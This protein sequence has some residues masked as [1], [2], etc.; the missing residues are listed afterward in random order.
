[1]FTACAADL[2]LPRSASASMK[3]RWRSGEQALGRPA[4]EAMRWRGTGV[5]LGSV[6]CAALR[7]SREGRGLVDHAAAPGWSREYA[8]GAGVQDGAARR[9]RRMRLSSGGIGFGEGVDMN[10]RAIGRVSGSVA[11]GLLFACVAPA[12]AEDE[13]GA[14][15]AMGVIRP[16]AAG[17]QEQRFAL[18][19]Q[20][21]RG[22]VIDL[23]RPALHPA[24]GDEESSAPEMTLR[25]LDAAGKCVQ[26]A[27]QQDDCSTPRGASARLREKAEDGA[28]RLAYRPEQGGSYTLIVHVAP[29]SGTPGGDRAELV[30]RER[31]IPPLPV[32]QAITLCQDALSRAAPTRP[33]PNEEAG[34]EAPATGDC[35]KPYAMDSNGESY[36]TFTAP[37]RE[38]WVR[39]EMRSKDIDSKVELL[40]PIRPAQ[41]FGDAPV[42]G[43]DDDAAGELNARL[44]QRLP[45]GGTYG[46][47]ASDV[48]KGSGAFTLALRG[49][50]PPPPP[51]VRPLAV[52]E[53]AGAFDGTEPVVRGH[54]PFQLYKLSGRAG[55][56]VTID[57]MSDSLDSFLEALTPYSAVSEASGGDSGYAVIARNDDGGNDTNARLTLRF[58]QDAAVTIRASILAGSGTTGNYTLKVTR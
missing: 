53:T 38:Q 12:H 5:K 13:A 42:I 57:M 55:D 25:L 50:P 45:G 27:P 14:R 9:V 41:A 48:R 1:M 40:G 16:V 47:R 18:D 17:E 3:P 19:L 54:N 58:E 15:L 4:V 28:I 37:N 33:H 43:D 31:P 20:A 39:I 36:F 8:M 24:S 2:T 21:G 10:R 6:C 7:S 22:V 44:V 29:A 52:G 23:A 46:I 35:D 56:V 51:Q 34:E 32:P 26:S 11:T 49:I 30:V